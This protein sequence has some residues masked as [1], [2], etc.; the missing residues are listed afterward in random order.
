MFRCSGAR[1]NGVWAPEYEANSGGVVGLLR[2]FDFENRYRIIG[3]FTRIPNGPAPANV[4]AV[5]ISHQEY[6]PER[7]AKIVLGVMNLTHHKKYAGFLQSHPT[8]L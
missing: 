1:A 8:P 6:F 5:L 3:R 7:G 2:S 4:S